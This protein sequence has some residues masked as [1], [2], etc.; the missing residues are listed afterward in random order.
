MQELMLFSP[1]YKIRLSNPLGIEDFEFD[2]KLAI[3]SFTLVP[4]TTFYVLSAND[5]QQNKYK[6]S[7]N[8]NLSN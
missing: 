8:I 1:R 6:E 2:C 3:L 4:S 7:T 5:L